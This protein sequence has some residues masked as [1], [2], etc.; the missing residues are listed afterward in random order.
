MRKL[1]VAFLLLFSLPGFASEV[2]DVSKDSKDTDFPPL[3]DKDYSPQEA[4][5]A[6]DKLT[7]YFNARARGEPPPEHAMPDNY[8]VIVQGADLLDSV[9]IN[10]ERLKMAKAKSQNTVTEESFLADSIKE[11][12]AYRKTHFLG[13]W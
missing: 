6:L 2:C 10:Q 12:C 9:R 1:V 13:D 11:Y 7:T 4:L 3:R 5:R 8:L